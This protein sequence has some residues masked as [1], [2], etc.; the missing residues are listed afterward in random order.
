[1]K[2]KRVRNAVSFGAPLLGLVLSLTIASP[3][4]HAGISAVGAGVSLASPLGKIS[5]TIGNATGFQA[6]LFYDSDILSKDFQFHL[7]GSYHAFGVTNLTGGK[8]GMFSLF[9]GAQTA[10]NNDRVRPFFGADLGAAIDWL[11]LQGGSTTTNAGFV[12]AARAISGLDVPLTDS[13]GLGIEMPVSF[14]FVRPALTIWNAVF[15]LRFKL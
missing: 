10:R 4:A 14:V 6:D 3:A 12:F 2:S 7:T 9:A 11:Q 1:M 5:Q 13:L 8:V 15:S